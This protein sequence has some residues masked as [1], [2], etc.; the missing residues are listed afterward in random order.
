LVYIIWR[1]KIKK[2]FENDYFDPTKDKPHTW[3][4]N[5]KK[6]LECI[7]PDLSLEEI[8]ERILGHIILDAEYNYTQ[9]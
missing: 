7:Y 3:C 4:L 9:I 6:I 8:N 1:K 5:Q 2:L